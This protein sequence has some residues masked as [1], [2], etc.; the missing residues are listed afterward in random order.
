MKEVFNEKET[1]IIDENLNQLK[2]NLHTHTTFSDGKY[3]LE[4]VIKKYADDGYDFIAITDHDIFYKEKTKSGNLTI[5]PG[6][7]VTCDYKGNEEKL[8][9]TYLHFNVYFKNN[10][11]DKEFKIYNYNDKNDLQLILNDLKKHNGLIQFNHPLFSRIPEDTICNLDGIN[12]LEIYN[13]KDFL[14][15]V[16]IDSFDGL[17][18][19]MLRNDK[20]ILLTANDD[21]HGKEDL[22]LDKIYRKAFNVVQGDNTTDNILNK[23]KEGYFYSSN[24]PKI[25]DYRFENGIFKIKTDDVKYIVFYSN[26]RHCKKIHNFQNSVNYGEYILSGLEKFIWVVIVDNQGNKAWTQPYWL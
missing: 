19:S 3:N 11:E 21:Y 13:N 17:I 10:D 14:D 1:I 26:L 8:N 20:K 7:E 16:G 23:I 9:G 18:L 25:Y 5:I 12:F 15:E 4:E 22:K 6:I 2:G 24:G